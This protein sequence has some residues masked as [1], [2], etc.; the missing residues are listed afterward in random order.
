MYVLIQTILH[1]NSNSSLLI[2]KLIKPILQN[3]TVGYSVANSTG[4]YIWGPIIHIHLSVSTW[5]RATNDSNWDRLESVH[6]SISLS[7]SNYPIIHDPMEPSLMSEN[8]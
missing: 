2:Y 4:L 8:L 5:C 1:E 6:V 7:P 3:Y